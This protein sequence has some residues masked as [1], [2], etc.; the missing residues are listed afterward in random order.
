M[1]EWFMK[2][3]VLDPEWQKVRVELVGHWKNESI[4]CCRKLFIYLRQSNP[5]RNRDERL[6][7]I[8]NYLNGTAFRIGVIKNSCSDD[9][10][11]EVSEEIKKKQA[12]GTITAKI[13]LIKK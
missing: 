3:L 8:R 10:R 11:K 4:E 7:I 6:L 9:L 5:K 13:K 12:N 2:D 1:K